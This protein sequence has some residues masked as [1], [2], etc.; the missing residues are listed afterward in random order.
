M[1]VATPAL[2]YLRAAAPDARIDVLA[3]PRN[4]SLLAGDPRADRVL[5][6]D[7]RRWRWLRRVPALR[8]ERYDLIVNTVL[9]FHLE[10]GWFTALAARRHT[11]RATPFRPAQYWGFFT[12]LGR[13]AGFE[14]RHVAERIL[15]AAQH[16]AGAGRPGAP[17]D[18]GAT[19][20]SL[21]VEP[22]AATRVVSFLGRARLGEFVAVN[23]WSTNPERSLGVEQTG[24]VVAELA[25]RFPALAFVL[26]PP[27]GLADAAEAVVR[28]ARALAPEV[29]AARLA[30]FPPS[31]RLGDLVALIGRAAVVLTPD[32]ANVH[33]ASATGRPV[34]GV[35]TTRVVQRHKLGLWGPLGVPHRLL[36]EDGDRPAGAM[37]P[38]VVVEAFESLWAEL[39]PP[40][41]AVPGN[42]GERE[43][44]SGA[45]R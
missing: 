33:L 3:S 27:P 15:Y 12:H 17:S 18:L 24:A 29:A 38:A 42:G 45:R 37:P 7:A 35:Y 31:R 11:T 28:A 6:H 22:A 39:H 36:V 1:A 23:C 10:Q 9:G 26:T 21:T 40:P 43:E 13:A 4:A 16:A 5:T 14:R 34:V 8:R 41:R 44:R 19:A 32:T 20:L 2:A 30:V 25:R